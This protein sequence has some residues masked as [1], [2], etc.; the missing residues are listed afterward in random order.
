M[1][2]VRWLCIGQ[3]LKNLNDILN[4]YLGLLFALV[5]LRVGLDHKDCGK[6]IRPRGLAHRWY[7]VFYPTHVM[8][9]KLAKGGPES[10]I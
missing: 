3:S 2:A 10:D 5:S 8:Q 7:Q 4:L 9:V 1:K 6:G